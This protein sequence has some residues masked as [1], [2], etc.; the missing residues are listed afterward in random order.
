MDPFSLTVGVAG[1]ISLAIEASRLARNIREGIKASNR[2]SR[3]F[4]QLERTLAQVSEM[5]TKIQLILNTLDQESAKA[6][7]KEIVQ[8]IE[9][10]LRVCVGVLQRIHGEVSRVGSLS[11]SQR[12]AEALSGQLRKKTFDDAQ[13]ELGSCL[14]NVRDFILVHTWYVLPNHR[15]RN[16]GQLNRQRC[17]AIQPSQSHP[18]CCETV[19]DVGPPHEENPSLVLCSPAQCDT[20]PTTVIR[21][22]AEREV[23][24][25]WRSVMNVYR[26]TSKTRWQIADDKDWQVVDERHELQLYLKIIPYR[27]NLEV[28]R[29][30]T[31]ACNV[32][33]IMP[34]HLELEYISAVPRSDLSHV[35]NMLSSGALSLYSENKHGMTLLHVSS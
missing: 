34:G 25:L 22:R 15:Q 16:I 2:M 13:E 31:F 3:E 27:L 17:M 12:V 28:G 5:C 1:L 6:Y 18:S 33:H 10:S 20:S 29:P 30:C 4:R 32:T 26:A 24:F 11:R 19:P 35:Q 23:L 8:G 21:Q 14:G 9:T 7:E